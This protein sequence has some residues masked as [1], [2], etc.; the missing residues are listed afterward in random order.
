MLFWLS[1]VCVFFSLCVSL[2]F[3][4]DYVGEKFVKCVCYLCG[5]GECLLVILEDTSS[6]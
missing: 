5:R 2:C 1:V 4:F 3:M 6:V